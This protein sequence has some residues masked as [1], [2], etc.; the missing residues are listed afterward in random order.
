[1]TSNTHMLRLLPSLACCALMLAA[2]TVCATPATPHAF[3]ATGHGGGDHLAK[4]DDD[5]SAAAGRRD[6]DLVASFY[7]PDAVA[8]PPGEPIAVGHDAAKRVWSRYFA[9]PS[10]SISWKTA[11][12]DV[13]ASGDL[14][15]TTGT[16]EA[17]SAGLDGKLVREIGKY[18]C[19]WKK[20]PDGRWKAIHDM[21]NTDAR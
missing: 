5:W 20:Q 4:L 10:F 12:A 15:F 13:S 7:A 14:G 19:V 11:H 9:D 18:S 2:I 21:W 1:M 3:S 17:S 16:Y 8:Y 6:L